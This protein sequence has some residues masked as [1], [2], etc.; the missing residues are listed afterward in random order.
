MFLI[1]IDDAQQDVVDRGPRYNI[2]PTQSIDSVIQIAGQHRQA[3][4]LRWGLVPSWANDLSIG[5][6]M[7]NARGETVD[8]KPSFRKAF[9]QRRC[10]IPA[11]GY[12]EWKKVA[13]GKQP[14]LIHRDDDAVIAMAGLWEENKKANSG[15]TIVRSCTIIT[16]NANDTTKEIHDRMPVILQPA[17]FDRWL[18]PNFHDTD[19]LKSML[20]PAPDT[21]LR[22]DA[23][24]RRVNRPTNDDASC[25]E[26]PPS[27]TLFD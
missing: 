20:K 21:L 10:L 27:D 14:Y 12:Y 7:I 8:L 15:D 2:A 23:V 4:K 6:R 19:R 5:N 22:C 24:S 9:A 18:D 13:D 11:D 17:D 26:P 3:V 16:T 25:I 1:D